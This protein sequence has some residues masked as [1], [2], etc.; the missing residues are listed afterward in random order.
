MR[1][2]AM[3]FPVRS[4]IAGQALQ[5]TS[6][7]LGERGVFVYCV[8]LPTL[9]AAA[10]LTLYLPTGPLDV[11]ATVRS[12]EGKPPGFWADFNDRSDATR[13]LILKALA[14]NFEQVETP[15]GGVAKFDPTKPAAGRN[16]RSSPRFRVR[17]PLRLDGR[18]TVTTDVSATGLSA[19]EEVL[20]PEG[21]LMRVALQLPD[22]Q[23]AAELIGVVIRREEGPE[24][25]LALQF[26][27]ADDSFRARLDKYLA[28][29]PVQP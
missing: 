28:G 25:G 8:E 26:A 17:L 18:E 5:T 1:S 22:E 3:T 11:P 29:K 10:K 20:A 7:E 23:P 15:A 2:M 19:L 12:V 6:R 14:S 24:R 9:H 13:G 27:G 16:R 21:T 4:E